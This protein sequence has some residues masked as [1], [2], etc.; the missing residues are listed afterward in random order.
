MNHNRKDWSARLNGS[1]QA[2]RTAY[3]TPLGM[4]PYRLV[5]GKIFHFPLELEHKAY[6]LVKQLNMKMN[7]AVQ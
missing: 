6:W 7:V 3:K 1:L 2:Y 4:S 5:Y